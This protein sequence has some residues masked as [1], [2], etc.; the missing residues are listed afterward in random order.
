[1]S[2][3]VRFRRRHEGRPDGSLRP[4]TS[5]TGVTPGGAAREAR[6]RRVRARRALPSFA[7]GSRSARQEDPAGRPGDCDAGGVWAF[8]DESE[9]AGVM[10]L[11]VVIVP[12]AVV[13]DARRAM[14][15]LLLPGQRRVHT[16][17][18]SARRQHTIL[19][20]VARVEDLNAIVLRHRRSPGTGRP[21]ARRLL[22]Q[23]ATG[24][25]VGAGVTAWIL[26]DQEPVQ[27]T[28]DRSVIAHAL[29]GVDAHLH[30][31][32]DHRASH[33]EPLL[34]AADAVCWAVGAAGDWRRRVEAIL[35]IWDLRP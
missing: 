33:T 11:A 14:Q 19:D 24:L 35:T 26:D 4:A 7:A 31:V 8:T 12:T 15:R 9:R 6:E 28:R 10:L 13:D 2:V 18:E 23:A 17:D 3:F 20:T 1:M 16:S 34:W 32:Y 22:L 21:A 25:A 27:R 5:R 30:P 29:G